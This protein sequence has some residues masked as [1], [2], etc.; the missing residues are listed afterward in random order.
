M[1]SEFHVFREKGFELASWNNLQIENNSFDELPPN[2]IA[3]PAA[4]IHK[5]IFNNNEIETMQP[6]SL[7]FIGK[8]ATRELE[9]SNNYYGTTCNCNISQWLAQALDVK[10]SENYEAHSYCTVNEVLARC[11]NVHDQN[12]LVKKFLK[13]VCTK[14][15]SIRCEQ[16]KS[17]VGNEIEIKNPR[18][19][20]KHKHE[21]LSARNKK[22][23]AIVIVSC[24]GC[25]LVA[26]LFSLY[27]WW[28]RD[29]EGCASIKVMFI[30]M[31]TACTS[32]CR[33]LCSCGPNV[34]IDNARSISQLSVHDYSERHRLNESR[35]Q[36][37]VQESSFQDQ[38]IVP[39]T[40]KFTQT[41]P[42]ELTKE[43]LEHLKERLDNPE[44]YVEARE[45]IEHLYE[46]TKRSDED[47]T[48]V[49]STTLSDGEENIYDLPY[50]NTERRVGPNNKQ[51]VS[52]GTR[53]PSLDKLM[54]L[55]PYQR[56]TALV[57]EYFEPRDLAVHL[58]AEI[59]NND[60]EK[61]TMLG[62]IPDIITDQPAPR[63]P[64]LQSILSPYSS[65]SSTPSKSSSSSSATSPETVISK[66]SN[67][68]NSSLKMRNRPLPEKPQGE[69]SRADTGE[70]TSLKLG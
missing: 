4:S 23:I 26:I 8:A 57:H 64:Y 50:E 15:S 24:L 59:A 46:L 67:P 12:M 30:S 49:F 7:S 1:N 47:P 11:F 13:E 14:S 34:G 37:S 55:S 61:R 19:P 38:L 22:V 70:G 16:I 18:F 48:L 5:L 51:V 62:V 3:A 17:K 60:K 58:Y 6:E 69:F 20:H 65:S 45:M 43:L 42:E 27:K 41:L 36:D 63:G 35:A 68:L 53:T 29:T 21:E 31:N 56:Q 33:R 10:E 66:R 52:V 54:P 40:E 39:T 44:N 28:R 9:Y 25:V 2:A 32:V